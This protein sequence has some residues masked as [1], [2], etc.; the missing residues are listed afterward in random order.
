MNRKGFTLLEMLIVVII[1]GVLAAIA[2][3][4]YI[5]TLEKSR[6]SEALTNIGTI[7]TSL[8]RYWYEY[9]S[10]PTDNDWDA[11]DIGNPNSQTQRLYNYTFVDEATS[12]TTRKYLVTATRTSDSTTYVKWQQ[13]DNTTGQFYKS[14]N[15]GG[16]TGP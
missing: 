7:R 6:S 4:Q 9:L 14:A 16:P 11:L 10:M 15:L 13:Q 12:A 8:D 5:G 1:I 2:M 3:P